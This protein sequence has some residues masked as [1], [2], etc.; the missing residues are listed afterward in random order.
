M[1]YHRSHRFFFGGYW[2]KK[3]RRP[4]H[5]DARPEAH[6]TDLLILDEEWEERRKAWSP[7]PPYI[8]AAA[9]FSNISS[10]S[11]PPAR[12]AGQTR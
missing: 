1:S 6:T 10:A 5:I 12:V 7:P 3:E 2:R 4:I 9:L 8:P 11:P